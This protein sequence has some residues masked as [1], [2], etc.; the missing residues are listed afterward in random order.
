MNQISKSFFVC[1]SFLLQYGCGN[2]DC[3]T[4]SGVI[5]FNYDGAYLDCKQLEDVTQQFAHDF[6]SFVHADTGLTPN[7]IL[8]TV[9][10][11]TIVVYPVDNVGA[12]GWSYLDVKRMMLETDDG[13]VCT[14]EYRHELIH[15][16]RSYVLGYSD[17]AGNEYNHDDPM[18]QFTSITDGQGNLLYPCTVASV[19]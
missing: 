16:L 15:L 7:E 19:D 14:S 9:H 10:G 13:N 5:T 4:P 18:F 8:Q 2:I 6:A 17:S 3:D 1:L 11:L 12:A